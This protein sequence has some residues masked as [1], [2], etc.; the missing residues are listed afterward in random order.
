MESNNGSAF[1]GKRKFIAAC[2][3]TLVAFVIGAGLV[4]YGKITG[5]EFVNTMDAAKYVVIAYLGINAAGA[6]IHKFGKNGGDK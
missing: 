4:A 3:Y 5:A 2:L 6:A 1:T